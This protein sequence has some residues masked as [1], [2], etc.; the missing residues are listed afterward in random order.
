MEV[1]AGGVAQIESIG[2]VMTED[3][4]VLTL[5]KLTHPLQ[6]ESKRSVVEIVNAERAIDGIWVVD[7]MVCDA[8][9]DG[10]WITVFK[11]ARADLSKVTASNLVEGQYNEIWNRVTNPSAASI[12][13]RG[14]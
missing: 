14:R 12:I 11:H 13:E 7:S 8:E 3:Q 10:K 2:Q 9:G 1:G 5:A 6:L 4:C